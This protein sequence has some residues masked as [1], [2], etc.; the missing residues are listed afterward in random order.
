[1]MLKEDLVAGPIVNVKAG[2]RVE[3]SHSKV[4]NLVM[5]RLLL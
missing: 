2:G 3:N 5:D 4:Y 1:M